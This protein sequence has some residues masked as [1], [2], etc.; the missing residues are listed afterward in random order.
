MATENIRAIVDHKKK[1]A[2]LERI[3]KKELKGKLISSVKY[4]ETLMGEKIIIYCA[5]PRLVLGRM[6][7]NVPKI[8]N[9]AKQLGLKN[10]S[11]EAIGIENPLLDANIVADLI[12]SELER[13]G[14]KA[15]R[16]IMMN[17]AQKVMEAGAVGVEIRLTGKIIG[18]R[19]STVRY[20]LGHMKK[21]GEV[22]KRLSKAIS[23]AYLP[24]GVVGVQVRI[25]SPNM[26]LPDEVKVKEYAEVDPKKLEQ[27]DPKL[28]EI[29][30]KK[31]SKSQS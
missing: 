3:L 20:F 27:I 1:E 23:H 18:E 14:S 2:A 13:Y 25:L 24:Q 30:D 31:V 21:S 15:A 29:L 22:N 12:A 26:R 10:P 9:I 6:N 28:L 5:R 19:T 16:R 7:S 4:V 17:I 8:I 11:V